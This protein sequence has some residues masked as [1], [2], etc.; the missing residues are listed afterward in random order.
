MI[1]NIVNKLVDENMKGDLTDMSRKGKVT[2]QPPQLEIVKEEIK[3]SEEEDL[4]MTEALKTQSQVAVGFESLNEDEDMV[5]Q[6]EMELVKEM[7]AEDDEK[8]KQQMRE[9]NMRNMPR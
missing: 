6:H 4:V 9:L 8:L 2:T 5:Q 7:D 3:V 1:I